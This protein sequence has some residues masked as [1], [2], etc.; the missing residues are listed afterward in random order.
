[1]KRVRTWTLRFRKVDR[2]HFEEIRGGKK[3]IETRAATPKYAAI[4]T[5]DRLRFVCGKREV[6]KRI[7]KRHHFKSPAAMLRKLP[8]K[9]IAPHLETPAELGAMYATY[10]SY[11]AKIKRYGLFAFE[12]K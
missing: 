7:M 3:S 6:T 9:R 5:G 10:P 1:M 2:A 11:P 4:A 8:L 12:L